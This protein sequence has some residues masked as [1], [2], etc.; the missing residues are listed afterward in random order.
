VAIEL[1]DD[2]QEE[3]IFVD[4][5]ILRGSLVIENTLAN[6][7]SVDYITAEN[8][9]TDQYYSIDSNPFDAISVQEYRIQGL[10]GHDPTGQGVMDQI[11]ILIYSLIR[12]IP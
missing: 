3:G 1:L 7:G 12:G 6:V 9:Y 4:K 10:H 11:G 2:L 5:V 8:P